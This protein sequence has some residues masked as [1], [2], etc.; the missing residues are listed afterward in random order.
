MKTQTNH[1]ISRD[2]ATYLILLIFVLSSLPLLGN[3]VFISRSSRKALD[4]DA[5]ALVLSIANNCEY[6]LW[7]MDIKSIRHTAEAYTENKMITGLKITGETGDIIFDYKKPDGAKEIKRTKNILH[8]NLYIGRIELSVS[9]LSI[10]E[11][12]SGILVTYLTTILI[13]FLALS[14][15]TRF[16]L[17][18]FLGTPMDTLLK[19]IEEISGGKYS[20]DFEAPRSREFRK[21]AEGFKRMGREIQARETALLIANKQL[22]KDILERKAMEKDR[23]R[24]ATSI[25][26]ASDAIVILDTRGRIEYANPAFAHISGIDLD[27]AMGKEIQSLLQDK[28]TFFPESRKIRNALSRGKKWR[29]RIDYRKK[30]GS[31][32]VVEASFTP[33]HDEKATMVNYVLVMHDITHESELENQLMQA[34]KMEA[35]GSLAGGIAHDFNNILSPIIGYTELTLSK[36]PKASKEHE[37]LEKVLSASSRAKDLVGQIL[38]LSRQR[39]IEKR[40]LPMQSITKETIKLLRA[41]I[42]S[43]IEIQTQIAD[44]CGEVLADYTQIQQVILNLCTN[45]YHSM[46][47]AT[48]ILGVELEK[49]DISRSSADKRLG[50]N[51]GPYVRLCVSDTGMGMPVELMERIF[52]PYFTTKE[53]GKGTGLGLS[54]VHGIVHDHGGIVRVYSEPGKGS[55]FQVYLPRIQEQ[56]HNQIP[57]PQAPLPGGNEHILIVDDEEPIVSVLKEMLEDLGYETTAMQDSCDAYAAFSKTPDGFDLLITDQTMPNMTGYELAKKVMLLKKEMP[58]IICTGFSE[59]ITKEKALS[60]GIREYIM[61]PVSKADMAHAIRRAL[62]LETRSL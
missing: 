50:L 41:S 1:S 25:E 31:N 5:N 62:K 30:E 17:Q 56:H 32:V 8:R 46:T 7:D 60:I 42:P 55:T 49:I 61:K 35:I 51:P 24:L 53:Q 4:K 58:V 14:I 26:Q 47:D 23:L 10:K 21:I 22:E 20:L 29:G 44:D 59:T 16:L 33:I 27:M 18:R 19:R 57:A 36:M 13:V 37:H 2:L 43:S 6:A 54:L 15:L 45:A 52:D 48:G 3:L 9:T 28:D 11:Y 12:L 40:P 38:T 34:Q 39:E